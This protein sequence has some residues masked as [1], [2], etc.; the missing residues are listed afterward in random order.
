MSIAGPSDGPREAVGELFLRSWWRMFASAFS[1]QTPE[2][3]AL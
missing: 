3:T 2:R 1:A